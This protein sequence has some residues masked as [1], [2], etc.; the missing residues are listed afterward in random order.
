MGIAFKPFLLRLVH[1][2]FLP[3]KAWQ[4]ISQEEKNGRHVFI[5]HAIPL[6]LISGA[7]DFIFHLN[8]PEF[9]AVAYSWATIAFVF[10]VFGDSLSIAVVVRFVLLLSQ[11]YNL[12]GTYSL[13]LKIV[14]YAITPFALV[15]ALVKFFPELNIL[16]ILGFYSFYI[17]YK[18]LL[19]YFS[20]PEGRQ[21]AFAMISI[22]LIVVVFSV[23]GIFINI[24]ASVL[25]SL[26]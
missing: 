7:A 26:I 8:Q 1:L 24:A 25:Y 21:T 11:N 13:F 19:A 10:S 14:S 18:G 2:I 6:L 4:N 20:F 22:L 9:N 15:S 17:F 3:E 16:Y 12:N 23:V 5:S